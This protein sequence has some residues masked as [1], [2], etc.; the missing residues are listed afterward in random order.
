MWRKLRS[1]GANIISSWI[2]QAGPGETPDISQHWQDICREVSSAERLILYVEHDDFPLKGAFIEAGIALSRG[3]PI[4]V[5]S[6]DCDFVPPRYRPIGS[7]ITHPLVT[8]CSL[9]QALATP[10]TGDK[11]P[12]ADSKPTL[13]V[14]VSVLLVDDVTHSVLLGERLGQSAAGMFSTPGGRLE[15]DE[16][17]FDCAVREC[18]EEVGIALD[19]RALCVLGGMEHFR[20][21]MHY[22]MFY[23]RASHWSGEITNKEPDKCK[24][25]VWFTRGT[26]PNNCT[27]PAVILDAALAIGE[28]NFIHEVHPFDLPSCHIC[29]CQMIPSGYRCASCGATTEASRP[30]VDL[31]TIA[32]E[33][34]NYMRTL[35]S[36]PFLAY[37]AHSEQAVLAILRQ[38]LGGQP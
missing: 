36:D 21:G 22:I 6:P 18:A 13:P 16:S 34:E 35:L 24:E 17:I 29:G 4:F 31:E 23:V 32:R 10:A 38:H 15:K 19:R 20:F 30:Q 26:I 1:E 27:E 33:I 3:I 9:E 5:V 28:V 25:W 37:A 8:I 12:A 7:W 11:V 14:G 2:D